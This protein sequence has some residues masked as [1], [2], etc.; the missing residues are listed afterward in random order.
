MDADTDAART[1]KTTLITLVMAAALVAVAG[2]VWTAADKWGGR[3][4]TTRRHPKPGWAGGG[5][6]EDVAMGL[7]NSAVR[8]VG[9]PEDQAR[10]GEE[11]N[12]D[13]AELPVGWRRLRWAL[14]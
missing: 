3:G 5:W 13:L 10:Y 1:A 11:W 2:G 12:A 8:A 14:G 6:A 9:Y 4:V 7:L